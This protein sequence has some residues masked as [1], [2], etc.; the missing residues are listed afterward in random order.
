MRGTGR[1]RRYPRKPSICDA[2]G[3]GLL[4]HSILEPEVVRS[5]LFSRAIGKLLAPMAGDPH[6]SDAHA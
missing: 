4:M 5:E 6:D 1:L 3:T 2:L